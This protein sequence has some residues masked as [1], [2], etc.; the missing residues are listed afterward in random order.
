[1]RKPVLSHDFWRLWAGRV[2]GFMGSQMG[3]VALRILFASA[4]A[5]GSLELGILSA[6]QTAGFL[7]FAI[8]AGILADRFTR[9]RLLVISDLV[10][11]GLLALI[12]IFA[13]LGRLN[14]YVVIVIAFLVGLGNL[15]FEISYK[16]LLPDI[17]P[18]DNLVL[19]NTR[20]ETGRTSAALTGP[21]IAGALLCDIDS[22]PSAPFFGVTNPEYQNRT[23]SF[24]GEET[25]YHRRG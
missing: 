7:V 13:L 11:A 1:M 16:S 10:R 24:D 12:P 14:L 4:L 8:P 17:V 5:A 23:I 15:L 25:F 19:A 22:K 2:A 21:L 3:D 9:R 20:L 18:N 6:A